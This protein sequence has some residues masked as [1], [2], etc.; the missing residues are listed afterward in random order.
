MVAALIHA[1]SEQHFTALVGIGRAYTFAWK[2]LGKLI[3]AAFLYA[4]ATFLLWMTFFGIPF[5]IY[6]AVRWVFCM[7]AVALEGLGPIEAL[8][9]SWSLVGGCW[10]RTFG[11]LLLFWVAGAVFGAAIALAVFWASFGV[12]T[13]LSVLAGIIVAPVVITAVTLLYYDT[14]LKKEIYSL[15]AL[16]YELGIEPGGAAA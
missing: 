4:G 10:W 16:A 2:R 14:R 13:L 8:S 15:N 3:A 7:H 11:I 9:R 5:A 12:S 6:L 1:V